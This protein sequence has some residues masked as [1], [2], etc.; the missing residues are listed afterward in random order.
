M[1]YADPFSRILLRWVSRG[2]CWGIRK[3]NHDPGEELCFF[4]GTQRLIVNPF[5]ENKH[6]HQCSET[7]L[8]LWRKN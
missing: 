2:Q 6:E 5:P 1:F 8:G 3:Q 7:L 4:H